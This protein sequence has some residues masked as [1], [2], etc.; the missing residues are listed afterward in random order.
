MSV[1]V[2]GV[3]AEMGGAPAPAPSEAEI[4]M[5]A[6]LTGGDGW[7][8]RMKSIGDEVARRDAATARQNASLAELNL[9]KAAKAAFEEGDQYREAQKE[10]LQQAQNLVTRT[11]LEC[12]EMRARA[13][14]ECDALIAEKTRLRDEA[15]TDRSSAA[16]ELAAA[17][18]ERRQ[19]ADERAVV[20]QRGREFEAGRA[21][22][23]GR[24]AK[25]KLAVDQFVLAA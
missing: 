4:I 7:I 20:A 23:E 8:R 2:G 14:A 22:L 10:A 19:L 3:S 17:V 13:K 24:A 12:D 25:V 21:E 18:G 1:S 16:E 15:A 11:Q 5:Q 6:S 9:G